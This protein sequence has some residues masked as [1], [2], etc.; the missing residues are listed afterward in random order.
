MITTDVSTRCQ[1]ILHFTNFI[2]GTLI[3]SHFEPIRFLQLKVVP[4]TKIVN[5]DVE[6]Y[7]KI[8]GN[9]K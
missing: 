6:S 5:G 1:F 4:R 9:I 7:C 8:L 3:V 2:S